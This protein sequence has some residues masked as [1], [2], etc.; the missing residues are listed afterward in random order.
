MLLEI[1]DGTISRGGNVVLDHFAFEIRGTEKIAV[2]GKNGAGKST[3]LSVITGENSL[4]PDEK[5]PDAGLFRARSF[6]VAELG[7]TAVEHPQQTVEAMA[8]EVLAQRF[9]EEERFC[10]ERGEYRAQFDRMF[11]ELG[12]HLEDRTKKL[13]QF[14][15][16]EQVK[17]LLIRLFLLSPEV[18]VLDEPTNHLD[19]ETSEW[20][21]ER[22]RSYPHAVVM[23]S[24]DRYFLDE[25]AEVVYEVQNGK[26]T[27]YAGN[28]SAYRQEKQRRMQRQLKA[29]EAQQQEIQRLDALIE[30]FK[31]KPRKAAFARSRQKI[32]DR[33]ERVEKPDQDD[34][35]LHSGEIAPLRT[36]SKNVLE[37][38][39][40]EIGYS[41][42]LRKLSLRIRRGQ[43]I[44]IFGPNGTGK[45]AF[46]KTA[47]GLLPPRK[48]KLK[49]GENIDIGYFD[50]MSASL[51]SEESVFDWFHGKF[52]VLEGKEIRR[53]LAGFL[54]HGDSLR[55]KVRDLSGGEKARL[56][57]AEILER[58]PNFLVLDEPTNNMDIPARETLE[59]IFR[60][61]KGTILFVSHDR[62]FLSHTADSLLLFLPGTRE[63]QYY[64]AGYENYRERRRR[65]DAGEDTSLARRSEEQ[66]LIEGLRSVPKK[67]TGMLRRPTTEESVRDW[68]FRLNRGEREKA[69]QAFRE[70]FPAEAA[71][72][73]RP[74]STEPV[75]P[76][77]ASIEPVSAQADTAAAAESPHP[78]APDEDALWEQHE[79]ESALER[80]QIEEKRDAWTKQCLDW[81]D[82]WQETQA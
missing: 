31:H 60:D 72:S 66:R 13:G 42:T 39:D 9:P 44:G 35:V 63:V 38:E 15:G 78:M 82:L 76:E 73:G 57:L 75:L 34:A 48:G 50:Q 28:Y 69:E 37:C 23:V 65:V 74:V 43:K 26:L 58:R 64:P 77:T 14:S 21:E 25:T 7:Q 24:H 47:A 67:E 61:Y 11:T 53:I 19:V 70:A 5:H 22:I 81:Y 71:D 20:L 36:G 8:D 68:Q 6:T 17:I 29:Y 16:G 49:T 52:P 45:S 54:F 1:R 41:D 4:D 32:L 40:L 62:Y 79:R 46:V 2:V 51:D 80:R 30:K 3:L 12:F 59:S 10:R 56:V 55:T 33:M 18:L 27:R